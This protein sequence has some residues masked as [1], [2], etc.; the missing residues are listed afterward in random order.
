MKRLLFHT[1]EHMTDVLDPEKY[2]EKC[3]CLSEG[4]FISAL[5]E[6]LYIFDYDE[7][8]RNFTTFKTIKTEGLRAIPQLYF[9]NPKES[10]TYNSLHLG[11][12]VRISEP[13]DV[14]RYAISVAC[15]FNSC[16]GFLEY[17]FND[18]LIKRE[19]VDLR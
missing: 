13:I 12:E 2:D 14:K 7:L 17:R 6:W 16:K 4:T 3:V 8:F 1:C 9:K 15:N 18:L 19:L 5:G 11:S 10:I